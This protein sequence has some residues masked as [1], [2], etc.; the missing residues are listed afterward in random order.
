MDELV[1]SSN[2]ASAPSVL[3]DRGTVIR[4]SPCLS[5]QSRGG[6]AG[7]TVTAHRCQCCKGD[8]RKQGCW[9]VGQELPS[10]AGPL[11]PSALP[12]GPLTPPSS[13]C[14][15]CIIFVCLLLLRYVLCIMCG[16][17][18][19]QVHFSC[20]LKETFEIGGQACYLA[21]FSQW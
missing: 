9:L 13:Q 7:S 20:L 16:G 1:Y 3:S 21:L 6:G 5:P 15:V 12:S 19:V 17:Q 4:Y 8:G 2:L 11:P 10:Q 14:P 18:L